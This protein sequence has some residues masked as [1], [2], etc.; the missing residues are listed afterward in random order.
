M[1]L[2]KRCVYPY[3]KS[4]LNSKP[5]VF[6]LY[7]HTKM[8]EAKEFVKND[9]TLNHY[10]LC[11]EIVRSIKTIEKYD[12]IFVPS[13][14]DRFIFEKDSIHMFTMINSSVDQDG[15]STLIRLPN[16]F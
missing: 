9:K 15:R 10:K 4:I 16:N 2:L 14:F 8:D 6:V 12:H 13:E 3:T 11:D 5:L 7:N 1:D